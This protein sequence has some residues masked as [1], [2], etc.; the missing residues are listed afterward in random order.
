MKIMAGVGFITSG[1]RRCQCSLPVISAEE[2]LVNLFGQGRS[3]EWVEGFLIRNPMF[4]RQFT[5]L[6]AYGHHPTINTAPL[7]PDP[8]LKEFVQRMNCAGVYRGF[9][10]KVVCRAP[11]GSFPFEWFFRGP[12]Q[13]DPTANADDGWQ[14]KVGAIVPTPRLGHLFDDVTRLLDEQIE[15]KDEGDDQEE[16]EEQADATSIPPEAHDADAAGTCAIPIA[17]ESGVV[18][19]GRRVL[20]DGKDPLAV[21]MRLSQ[22]GGEDEDEDDS[23]DKNRLQV[24]H[25]YLHVGRAWARGE[26]GPGRSLMTLK[27]CLWLKNYLE[28]TLTVWVPGNA[29]DIL[30]KIA[31]LRGGF[32][33]AEAFEEFLGVLRGRALATAPQFQSVYP[34][35]APIPDPNP[36]VVYIVRGGR[37]EIRK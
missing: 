9:K 36:E 17:R 11:F 22:A 1:R 32:E 2:D 13:L 18:T 37:A 28:N 12:R 25:L 3:G 16:E 35:V 30:G 8:T 15:D 4:A 31:R 20:L 6:L 33:S 10:A 34:G 19:P 26:I 24:G 23:V 29:W 14:M 7:P 5:W 27:L 21:R